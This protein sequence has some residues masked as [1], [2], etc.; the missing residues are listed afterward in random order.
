MARSTVLHLTSSLDI[1]TNGREVVDLAIH[2]HRLGWR[3]VVASAGGSLVLEAERAAVRH[4]RMPLN[5]KN[6]FSLWRARLQLE[7]LFQRERPHLIHAH[8]IDV[9]AHA[10]SLGSRHRLP[11]LIDVNDPLPATRRIKKLLHKAVAKQVGFR[12]PSSFMAK[13]LREDHQLAG[14]YLHVIPPGVDLPWFDAARVSPERLQKVSEL[15][16][17]PEQATILIMATPLA[18][19][20]GHRQILESLRR[21]DRRDVFTVFVGDDR[22]CPGTRAEIERLI[23]AMGLEGRVVMPEHCLDWPAACWL[24]TLVLATNTLPRGQALE[25]LAAQAL[26]RPVIVTD[27]GANVEMVKGGE[28]AWVVPPDN[29]DLMTQALGEAVQMSVVQRIDLAQRTRQFMTERFS[30]ERS[31]ASVAELY[32]AML[33]HPPVARAV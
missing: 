21:L 27:C 7:A 18:P 6:I 13:H 14:D 9:L 32:G 4:T 29:V 11:I 1:A 16:H 20:Y 26:G 23:V 3:P 12:V 5:K 8:G 25:L 17:L 28:T 30:H 31:C 10:M 24:S 19:G 15:W 22:L 2:T 33:G